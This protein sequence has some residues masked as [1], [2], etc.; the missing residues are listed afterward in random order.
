MLHK[1]IAA[2][3]LIFSTSAFASGIMSKTVKVG[4]VDEV[5]TEAKIQEVQ[6]NLIEDLKTEC[7]S[8]KTSAIDIIEAN[9]N[10][11]YVPNSNKVNGSLQ[12]TVTVKV[13]CTN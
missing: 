2:S 7:G 8:I 5:V 1:L 3:I 12:R 11:H 4:Q 9:D 6:E 10:H 13:F